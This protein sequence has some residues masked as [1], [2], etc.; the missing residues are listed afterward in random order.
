MTTRGWSLFEAIEMCEA[1]DIEAVITLKST[2]SYT[3]LGDL[4]E[5]LFAGG[6]SQWGQLRAEDG[7]PEPYNIS[8]FEIGNEIHTQDFA[9][10]ALAMEARAKSIG[11]GGVLKYACPANCG[12]DAVINASFAVGRFTP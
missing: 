2:E 7:H 6:Q 12:D 8:W 10:R 5:Y 3:D 4:V 9:G 1:L 11:K